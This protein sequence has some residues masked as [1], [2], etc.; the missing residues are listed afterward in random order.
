[1]HHHRHKMHHKAHGG[2]AGH[3][4]QKEH[5]V[6]EKEAYDAKGSKVEREAEEKG[7]GFKRGGRHKKHEG[8]AHGH[9][10]KHRLDKRARGGRT[11]SPFS[12]AHRHMK[13]DA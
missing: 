3:P 5:G 8:K 11:G 13:G 10:G 1:M 2:A 12:S 9:K 6:S 7:D 4:S